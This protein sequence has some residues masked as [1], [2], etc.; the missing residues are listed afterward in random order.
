MMFFILLVASAL[1][2][3]ISAAFFSVYGLTLLFNSIS[4]YVLVMGSAL[5]FSKLMATSYL[6][7]FWNKTQIWLKLYLI[8][9]IFTLMVLTSM[10]I[11]G[12]LSMGYQSDSV[13]LKQIQQQVDMLND[14]KTRLVYRKQQ[15]DDQIAALPSNYSKSRISVMKEFQTEQQ[16]ITSRIEVLQSQESEL[17]S[18]LIQT[19]SHVGP[20]IYIANVL[21][22]NPDNATK[23]M[24]YLI[25][26]VF[27]PMAVA[28]TLAV[29]I[30]LANKYKETPEPSEIEISDIHQT[31]IQDESPISQSNI[32]IDEP[33][34]S[35]I[36]VL[37][38]HNNETELEPNVEVEEISEPIKIVNKPITKITKSDINITDRLIRIRNNLKPKVIESSVIEPIEQ[39]ESSNIDIKELYSPSLKQKNLENLLH[40]YHVYKNKIQMGE[41]LTS[42]ETMDFMSIRNQLQQSGFNVNI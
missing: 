16:S 8:I 24:I 10:G 30:V 23:Y 31:V 36:D 28:L 5:E 25:I 2:L 15:I 20:I 11:F 32:P 1:T 40:S 12:L 9:G 42:T 33:I 3:A 4:T 38:I 39:Q 34:L 17:R 37:D 6:Y 7:R 14:E 29:N 18:K 19:E 26:F 22:L 13:P 35:T 21:G 41:T 27:D